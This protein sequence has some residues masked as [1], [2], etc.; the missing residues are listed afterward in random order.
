MSFFIFLLLLLYYLKKFGKIFS[1]LNSIFCCTSCCQKIVTK[2]NQNQPN[3]WVLWSRSRSVG[4]CW[5]TL[6]SVGVYLGLL[7][8]VRVYRVHWCPSVFVG[9]PTGFVGIIQGLLGVCWGLCWSVGVRCGPV[10][11]VGVRPCPGLPGFVGVCHGF[12][13]SVF[14]YLGLP[15][16]IWPLCL[17]GGCCCCG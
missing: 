15:W 1:G 14:G 4:V 5:I 10:K 8:C 2:I 11:S 12:T 16:S 7:V 13:G 3:F 17:F 9:G 6:G